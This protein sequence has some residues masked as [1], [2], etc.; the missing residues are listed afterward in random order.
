MA[1]SAQQ[2]RDIQR[3]L[4]ATL[5]L[6]DDNDYR[7]GLKQ[8]HQL[9]QKYPN[10]PEAKA[11][12]AL[13]LRAEKDREQSAALMSQAL[14]AD[15][16]NPRI[17]K[18]QGILHKMNGDYTKAAQCLTQSLNIDKS[19]S[20]ILQDLCNLLFYDRNYRQFL[21]RSKQLVQ[22]TTNSTAIMRYAV[23]LELNGRVQSAQSF[24]ATYE[25]N[26][27]PSENED[28]LVFR[29]E[30]GLHIANLLFQLGRFEDCITYVRGNP[31]IR[32]VTTKL[33]IIANAQI[34][35]NLK[36]DAFVTLR[37]LIQQYPENGDYFEVI[38]REM[39]PEDYITELF[40][41][42]DAFRS[43]YAVRILELLP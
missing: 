18:Y 3:R 34:A 16:K 37:E 41:L 17:W 12:K 36:G 20:T 1:R 39:T 2:E 43:R 27:L 33:E 28:E 14:R 31:R 35:L 29:S 21:D 8:L 10:H 22:V 23:G 30:L 40:A 19:D 15:M 5:K 6:Y 13:F 38:E 4:T 32:D 9:L 25:R 11:L 24:L 7:R 42:R 26:L